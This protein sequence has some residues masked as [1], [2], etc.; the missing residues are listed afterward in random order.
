MPCEKCYFYHQRKDQQDRGECRRFPP[1][2]SQ[3]MKA[4]GEILHHMAFG[5]PMVFGEWECGE[6]YASTSEN[7]NPDTTAD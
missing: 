6:F 2:P 4:E 1:V 7:R 3:A 5:F